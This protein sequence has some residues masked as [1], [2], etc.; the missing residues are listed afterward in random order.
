MD[1]N[2][3]NVAHDAISAQKLELYKDGAA[4]DNLI[5][6]LINEH[7]RE[8]SVGYGLERV[9]LL[10]PLLQTRVWCLCQVCKHAQVTSVVIVP[11]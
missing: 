8:V 1:H 5:G 9:K 7:D 6:P 10:L 11:R 4:C 3:L 2:V